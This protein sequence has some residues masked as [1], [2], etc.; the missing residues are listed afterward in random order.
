MLPFKKRQPRLNAFP[1]IKSVL[2]NVSIRAMEEHGMKVVCILA[3]HTES[4]KLQSTLWQKEAAT[5]SSSPRHRW[6]GQNCW[7]FTSR[8]GHVSGPCHPGMYYCNRL[9]GGTMSGFPSAD[10]TFARVLGNQWGSPKNGRPLSGWGLVPELEIMRSSVV[11]GWFLYVAMKM[12]PS[13]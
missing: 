12:K 6:C 1:V 7:N 4:A 10:G 5:S 13:S 3:V 9:I 11:C 8:F 2:H